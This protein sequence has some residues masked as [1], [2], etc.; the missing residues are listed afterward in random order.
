MFHGPCNH[1]LINK[2]E[3]FK[4]IGIK[5]IDRVKPNAH[6]GHKKPLVAFCSINEFMRGEERKIPPL[7]REFT[8]YNQGSIDI[9]LPHYLWPSWFF[10][11]KNNK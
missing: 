7:M 10:W 5:I 11:S 9:G 1:V 6:V 4:K 8:I 3:W 2:N